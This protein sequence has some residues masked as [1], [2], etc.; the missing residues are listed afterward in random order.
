[1]IKVLKH[2]QD[3]DLG[4]ISFRKNSRAKRYIIRCRKE[5]VSITIPGLGNLREAESFF[6]KN[7]DE[8]IPIIQKIKRQT[9]DGNPPLSP[10]NIV[11]LKEKAINYLP[12]ELARLAQ[13]FKFY[14][15]FCKIGKSRTHW[16]SCSSSGTIRLSFYLMLLP[17][18][19]I[20]YVLLHELCHT[21]HH[22]HG[23]GFWSLLNCCTDG[24]AKLLRKELR[25]YSIPRS[26]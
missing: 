8:L 21:V 16:G 14:Y 2:F 25:G 13:N 18:N 24:K 3:P 1:M 23:E 19:L 5:K 22:N 10:E 12:A 6:E 9:S 26:L 17:E 4:E 7:R 15:K 20:Q 11:L